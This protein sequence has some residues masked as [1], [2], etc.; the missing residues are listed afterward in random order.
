MRCAR[1]L[2]S[3]VALLPVPVVAVFA[4][5]S[6]GAATAKSAGLHL[7]DGVQH[8]RWE[9]R[10]RQGAGVEQL[11]VGNPLH[12]IQLRHADRACERLILENTRAS[13]VV[14]YTCRG[15]G[16]GRTH[17]R[18]ETRHLIQVETQGVVDGLPFD[19]A[20]EGRWVGECGGG[21]R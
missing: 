6:V 2:L 20:A 18:R 21:Q 9:L 3:L 19:F 8:G 16:F 11:C 14:Q 10:R 12:L 15:H 5:S 7:L 17:I 1:I 13:A 4:G